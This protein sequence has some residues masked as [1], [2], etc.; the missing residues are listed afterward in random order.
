MLAKCNRAIRPSGSPGADSLGALELDHC[1]ALVQGDAGDI[2]RLGREGQ[3]RIDHRQEELAGRLG[4]QVEGRL[5]I[6]LGLQLGAFEEDFHA[7][8]V[9]EVGADQALQ[10]LDRQFDRGTIGRQRIGGPGSDDTLPFAV[11]VEAHAADGAIRATLDDGERAEWAEITRKIGQAL[12]RA[13][14]EFTR[15]VKQLLILRSHIVKAA[16]AK[17]QLAADVVSDRYELGQAWLV[18]C[19]STPQLEAVREALHARGVQTME[20]FSRAQGAADVDLAEFS[21]R[22]GVML[23]IACLDEGVDIPRISHALILASSTTRR[24][25][26]QRRGRVL[27]Q[28]DSKTMA[29]IHD[30]LV[31]PAGFDDPQTATFVQREMARAIEFAAPAQASDAAAT[32]LQLLANAY[33]LDAADAHVADGM[34]AL[35]E[36]E[37]ET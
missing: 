37:E 35:D 17:V 13:D 18:Y 1:R 4:V 14:G 29:E 3:C 33:G 24:Q 2:A 34:D 36:E 10:L 16:R 28:H 21:E 23:S 9:G 32:Q 6:Q 26:I 5:A 31:I 25:F 19:D 30:A 20:F 27:R 7:H 12:G 8:A 11:L 22:G 15:G